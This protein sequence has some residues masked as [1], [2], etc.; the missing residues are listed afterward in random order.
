[1]IRPAVLLSGLLLLG[2]ATPP[3]PDAGM[4]AVEAG[5]Y[6]LVMGTSGGSCQALGG[7]GADICRVTEGAAV[8][9]GWLIVLPMADQLVGGEVI[10]RY[11][12]VKRSYAVNGPLLRIPFRDLLDHDHYS[13]TDDGL[14]QILGSLE[15]RGAVV[16]QFLDVLGLGFL[17][18]LRQGYNP[19]PADSGA[20][21]FHTSCRVGYTTAGRSEL[22]CSK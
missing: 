20:T 9:D 6:T 16:N 2:C 19:L 5:D 15:Y 12:G 4:P 3:K 18:V 10:A 21:A 17:V 13:L 22:Q 8:D 7:R 1:M 11:R 14:M